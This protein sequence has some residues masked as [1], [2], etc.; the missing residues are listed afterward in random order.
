MPKASEVSVM[1]A[2]GQE[3]PEMAPPPMLPPGQTRE[4]IVAARGPQDND[5]RVMMTVDKA[6]T[7]L[8]LPPLRHLIAYLNPAL[9]GS[10]HQG[11][12]CVLGETDLTSEI[13]SM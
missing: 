13:E 8:P 4:L 11:S 5:G 1:P 2:H 6:L 7:P 10:E 9:Y 12:P 3:L